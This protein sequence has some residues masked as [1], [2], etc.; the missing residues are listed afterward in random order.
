MQRNIVERAIN[1]GFDFLGFDEPEF[2]SDLQIELQVNLI[3]PIVLLFT[4]LRFVTVGEWQ[5]IL[6]LKRRVK[7]GRVLGFLKERV[8]IHGGESLAGV[9]G[10][11]LDGVVVDADPL[12]GVAD[13][14]VDGEV[15]EEGVVTGGEVELGEGGV[16]DVEVDGVGSED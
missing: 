4:V 6:A 7:I 11:G 16:F 14:H 5:Q 8:E 10:A 15:V 3:N 9:D 2:E 13:G 12:V 1:G